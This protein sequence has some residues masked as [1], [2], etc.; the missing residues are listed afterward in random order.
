MAGYAVFLRS[1]KVRTIHLE[2]LAKLMA[3]RSV[4]IPVTITSY[5]YFS[6][7]LI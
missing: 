7:R 5:N 1:V 2:V 3:R 6:K 4:D